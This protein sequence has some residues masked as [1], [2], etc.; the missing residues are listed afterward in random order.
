MAG[1]GDGVEI[2][3][4]LDEELEPVC[5][6]GELD[7]REVGSVT[8]GVSN[9]IDFAGERRDSREGVSVTELLPE[10]SEETEVLRR[11]ENEMDSR[12]GLRIEEVEAE[13]ERVDC[14]GV[15]FGLA[16][17]CGEERMLCRILELL[18]LGVSSNPN[19]LNCVLTEVPISDPAAPLC[20]LPR[21]EPSRDDLKLGCGDG[22]MSFPPVE[23]WPAI[24]GILVGVSLTIFAPA[25]APRLSLELILTE[26]EPAM[27]GNCCRLPR[28]DIS[29][30]RCKDDTVDVLPEL[31]EDVL[32]LKSLS[33]SFF[34][35][36]MVGAVT[37]A[38]SLEVDAR[39]LLIR[40]VV[41]AGRA[42]T[43]I[44]GNSAS[45]VV[46][47]FFLCRVLADIVC[48]PDP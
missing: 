37:P 20:K 44:G 42:D 13:D 6:A 45:G 17:D 8:F 25:E 41:T 40:W 15:A 16:T 11:P 1:T 14:R 34:T 22:P 4:R 21:R 23:L 24:L 19:S 10:T 48:V 32:L 46:E 26:G 33:F 2:D 47:V 43:F 31:V 30:A 3:I 36:L 5:R 38:P 35:L 39:R 9:L 29:D 28:R 18:E 27:V 12:V 7:C